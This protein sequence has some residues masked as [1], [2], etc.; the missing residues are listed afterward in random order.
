M[1]PIGAGIRE[2][3][4]PKQ[5]Q[6]KSWDSLKSIC[7]SGAVLV[8]PLSLDFCLLVQSSPECGNFHPVLRFLEL[9]QT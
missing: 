6:R 1:L 7:F 9:S 4:V 3:G 2:S 5:I 8:H